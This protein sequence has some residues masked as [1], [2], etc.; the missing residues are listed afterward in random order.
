MLCL[1][2]S[3]LF[4]SEAY[5]LPLHHIQAIKEWLASGNLSIY[6]VEILQTRKVSTLTSTYNSYRPRFADDTALK[7]NDRT[8]H[9]K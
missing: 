7:Y 5:G 9:R 6:L 4:F 2:F 1:E 3:I 8:C